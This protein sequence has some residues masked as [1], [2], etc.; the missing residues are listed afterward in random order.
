M[1]MVARMLEIESGKTP[2]R[3]LSVDEAVAHGAAIYAGLLLE[4]PEFRRMSVRNVN[5]T[6]SAS[7]ASNPRPDVL[8]TR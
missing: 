7:S 6:T 3:S 1:P 4:N 2:D 5:S 8:A